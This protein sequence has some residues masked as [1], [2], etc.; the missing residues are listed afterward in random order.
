MIPLPTPG[1]RKLTFRIQPEHTV[2]PFQLVRLDM[3]EWE[4]THMLILEMIFGLTIP[5]Q[6]RG[7][8]KLTSVD[9]EKPTQ[10]DFLLETKDISA[11]GF[12]EMY[13]IVIFG[14]TIPP[15]IR[16]HRKLP[17]AAVEESMQQDFL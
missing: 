11:Q 5:H 13:L 10:S 3:L 2:L 14:N 12:P 9:M 7:R 4:A 8:K 6:I 1:Y 16:G 17:L 15:L